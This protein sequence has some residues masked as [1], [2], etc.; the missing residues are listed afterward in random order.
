MKKTIKEL[1]DELGVSKQAIQKRI[2]NLPT[3]Q[4]PTMVGGRY[5][6][7]EELVEIIRSQYKEDENGRVEFSQQ[8][9]TANVVDNVLAEV[10]EDLKKDKIELFD[11]MKEKDKQIDRLQKLLDQQQVLT[12]Q[13]NK[14]IAELETTLNV[15]EENVRSKESSDDI[16]KE[17]KEP[18][19]KS[20][21]ARLFGR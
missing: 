16:K 3:N 11:S 12:L 17:G 10:V 4:Q 8:P 14:K 7:N 15:E 5:L 19:K 1:A 21:F 18:E 9:T 20:F 13:A 2:N 6:L